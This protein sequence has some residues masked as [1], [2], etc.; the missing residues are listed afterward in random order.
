[1]A[2]TEPAYSRSAVD[3]AGDTLINNNA[4][5]EETEHALT[6]LNNWRSSHSYPLQVFYMNLRDRARTVAPNA[7]VAQ[8]LK[9]L[10]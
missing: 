10:T 6:V 7:L 2:F 8:R 4:T 9:R 3:V 1:M 5:A